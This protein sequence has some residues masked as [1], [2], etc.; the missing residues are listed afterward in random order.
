MI[1]DMKS[2]TDANARPSPTMG[3]PFSEI[4]PVPGGW[5]YIPNQLTGDR[6]GVYVPNPEYWI[7]KIVDLVAFAVQ[8][9]PMPD[10]PESRETKTRLA[11]VLAEVLTRAMR[12]LV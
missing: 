7:G 4:Q 3:R 12:P 5:I 1:D 10:D 8:K 11:D 6:N 2:F 9:A